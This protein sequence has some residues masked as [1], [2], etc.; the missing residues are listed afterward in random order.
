MR[1][2][3]KIFIDPKLARGSM[4]QY[5]N[6]L[7]VDTEGHCGGS[8][9]ISSKWYPTLRHLAGSLLA[10]FWINCRHGRTNRHG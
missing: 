6:I 2:R 8:W 1:V 3:L 5:P 4:H 9:S 10:V 7:F